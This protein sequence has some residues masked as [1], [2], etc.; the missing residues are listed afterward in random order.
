MP[1]VPY[2]TSNGAK[3]YWEERGTGDPI[4]LIMGLGASLEAWDRTAPVLAARY[5]VIL[6]DN[7]GVG[8]SEVPPGPYSLEVMADDA[9]A[10]LDAA[11]VEWAHVYGASMGGMIAQE[12]ALR[13]PTRVRKL[14][15]GC[16][17]C[18][19]REVVRAEPDVVAALNARAKMP[20]EEAMWMMA[21]HIYDAS[22]PRERIEE[23]FRSRLSAN[24]SNEGYAAQYQ[25][26][27]GWKG[28]HA[29]LG[30]LQMPTL[31]IHGE[32]DRLVPPD[33]GRIIARAIPGSK[34]LML[35]RASHIYM[36]DQSEA[37]SAAIMS[38][39]QE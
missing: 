39:L 31:V 26:I 37:A 11:G 3:L 32:T 33:N 19:G 21:P 36:T 34:L 30:S 13:H 27:V 8:R 1:R 15:L 14:I 22:T 25:A 7:R 24:G 5:R 20:R 18:G 2:V 38:F 10:V 17:A 28:S 9:A 16:T 12:F 29:R 4:L 23:D 35:P 6:F